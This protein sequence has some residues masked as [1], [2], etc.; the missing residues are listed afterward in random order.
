MLR[1]MDFYINMVRIVVG[2]LID[3]GT[4]K[5]KPETI[6]DIIDSKDRSKAGKNCTAT[7]VMFRKGILL[8]NY[9]FTEKINVFIL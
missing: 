6:V 3:V 4:N 9:I 1:Q 5:I 8:I 2:T 7:R